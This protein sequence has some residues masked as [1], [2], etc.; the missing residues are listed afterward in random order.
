MLVVKSNI[1]WDSINT[2]NTQETNIY[3]S[4]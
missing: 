3:S 2:Q 1:F 4:N